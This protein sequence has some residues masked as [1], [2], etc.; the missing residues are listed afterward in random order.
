MNDNLKQLISD[1]IVSI[2]REEALVYLFRSDL[3]VCN[4]TES[5]QM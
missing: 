4:A 5:L 1:K 3:C 2:L